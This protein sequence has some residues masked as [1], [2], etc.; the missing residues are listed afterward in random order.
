MKVKPIGIIHS[1]FNRRQAH[2]YSPAL[3][4]T[5]RALWRFSRSSFP[6]SKTLKGSNGSG[7]SIGST[8][9]NLR[10]VRFSG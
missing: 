7:F 6:A 9:Q 10:E 4:K 1:P 2:R 8:G 5:Q 3:R